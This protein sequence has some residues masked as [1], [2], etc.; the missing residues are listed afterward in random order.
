MAV[1]RE[2][3]LDGVRVALELI[4]ADRLWEETRC[5]RLFKSPL[6]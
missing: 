4:V 1:E 3:L 2:A 5:F 6:R